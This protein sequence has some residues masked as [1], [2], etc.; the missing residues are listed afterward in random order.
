MIVTVWPFPTQRRM[1]VFTVHEHPSPPVDRIDRA[2]ALLFLKDGFS[3]SAFLF[4]PFWLL[5]NRLWLATA[6]YVAILVAVYGVLSMCGLAEA[7][8]G[9]MLLALNAILGF[10]AYWLRSSKLAD[11]G[12]VTLG[13]VCGRGLDDCERRFFEGWLSGEPMLRAN[14]I[15]SDLSETALS[16]TTARPKPAFST[17]ALARAKHRVQSLY[18]KRKG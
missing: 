2:E 5:A 16:N 9:T 13:S 11:A 1:T 12:W 14:S 15:A 6:V 17:R 4:G 10:E 7:L 18:R 8:L 3:W